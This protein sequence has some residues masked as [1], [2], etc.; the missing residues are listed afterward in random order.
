MLV[1]IEQNYRVEFA[2]DFGFDEVTYVETY[3]W[4]SAE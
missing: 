1:H 4:I 2:V 3:L